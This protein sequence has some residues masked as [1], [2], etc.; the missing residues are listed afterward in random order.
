M[1][2]LWERTVSITIISTSGASAGASPSWT[3]LGLVAEG[4][5]MIGSGIRNTGMNRLTATTD[6]AFQRYSARPMENTIK[7]AKDGPTHI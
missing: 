1:L 6:G 3:L 5:A 7:L 4:P 2:Q